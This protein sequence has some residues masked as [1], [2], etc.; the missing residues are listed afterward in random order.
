[1]KSMVSLHPFCCPLKGTTGK[2]K[3]G[4][5]RKEATQKHYT[6]VREDVHG[7]LNTNRQ[8]GQ[9][10][11]QYLKDSIQSLQTQ[12]KGQTLVQLSALQEVFC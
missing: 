10:K 2:R 9:C 5:C 6:F 3:K 11:S 4:R 8:M 7:K 1:M 12:Q